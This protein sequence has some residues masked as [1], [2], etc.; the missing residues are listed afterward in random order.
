MEVRA[1]SNSDKVCPYCKDTLG[2]KDLVGCLCCKTKLHKECFEE[3]R[4]CTSMGCQNQNARWPRCPRCRER[5]VRSH[6]VVCVHCGYHLELH[7]LLETE[8]G[9]SIQWV[10]PPWMAMTGNGRARIAHSQGQRP[11]RSRAYHIGRMALAALLLLAPITAQAL[12]DDP[13]F[14]KSL[15]FVYPG[16]WI[17]IIILFLKK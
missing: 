15:Y 6:A 3:N 13:D 8:N 1:V 16:S 10:M 17:L 5:L 4:G 9:P 14:E 7:E 12:I 2:T 11:P